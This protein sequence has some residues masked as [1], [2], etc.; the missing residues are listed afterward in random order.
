MKVAAAL[1]APPRNNVFV[2]AGVVTQLPSATRVG[3]APRNW[4]AGPLAV[5][6]Y[7]GDVIS[8]NLKLSHGWTLG[9]P[10]GQ[11]RTTLTALRSQISVG[12]GDGWSAGVNSEMDY[13]WEGTGR[14]RWTV[15]V[16]L[17]LSR[18]LTLSNARALQIGG[19]ITHY[20]LPGG[21][22]RAVWEFG[23]NLT[24]VVPRGYFL[25]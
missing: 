12:L 3:L 9:G 25:R 16:S 1:V 13:D 8:A 11:T 14:A 4:A 18:V 17:T 20:A 2:A 15:P 21:P 7:Q 22:Q 24:F 5:V 10:T 19:L 6:G 23:L